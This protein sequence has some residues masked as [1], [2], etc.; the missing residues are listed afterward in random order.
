MR[1]TSV[2]G[3]VESGTFAVA[4]GGAKEQ[5]VLGPFGKA[6]EAGLAVS[7]GPNFQIELAE[8]HESVGDVDLNVGGIE[9][10]TGIVGDSEIS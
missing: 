8:V 7:V 2:G 5:A 1:F 4:L 6:D 3:I 10:R 9:G